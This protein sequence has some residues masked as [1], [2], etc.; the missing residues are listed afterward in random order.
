[1][2]TEY[3]CYQAT[4]LAAER[5]AALH[6]DADA[7]R[8]AAGARRDEGAHALCERLGAI[9]LRWGRRLYE[10]GGTASVQIAFAPRREH[11]P[12]AA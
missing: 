3:D 5:T 7:Y 12:H 6:R 8:A 11:G 10:R 1:M 4:T 9:L 2:T